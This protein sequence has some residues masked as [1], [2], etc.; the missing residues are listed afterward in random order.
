V[1]STA[2]G[3]AG[4]DA[5]ILAAWLALHQSNSQTLITVKNEKKKK[6]VQAALVRSIAHMTP[7]SLHR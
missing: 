1:V 7:V 3:S 5:G 2:P 4:V 6:T